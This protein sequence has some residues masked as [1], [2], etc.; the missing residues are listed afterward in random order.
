VDTTAIRRELAGAATGFDKALT[1]LA[2]AADYADRAAERMLPGY[3]RIARSITRIKDA[4]LTNHREVTEL[5]EAITPLT[6]AA[7]AVTDGS[8]PSEV[9]AALTPVAEELDRLPRATLYT[10]NRRLGDIEVLIRQRLEGGSP[11]HLQARVR[12]PR[13]ILQA[14]HTRLNKAKNATEAVLTAAREAGHL[15]QAGPAGEGGGPDEDVPRFV[16]RIADD[17]HHVGSGSRQVVAYLVDRDGRPLHDGRLLSGADGPGRGRPGLNRTHA[18]YRW[19]VVAEHVE[20][21][22]AALLRRSGAPAEAVL[23]VSRRPCRER[24]GC[25]WALPYIIHSGQKLH[26]YLAEPGRRPQYVHTYAGNGKAVAD[27]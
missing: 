11:E 16:Q 3:P 13:S 17:F 10:A 4:I 15:E 12:G 22:A 2:D 1:G 18:M 20:G 23:V 9:I 5:A 19:G 21:H 24:Q 14:V 7:Q 26:V 6:Q 8:T 27:G 25:H